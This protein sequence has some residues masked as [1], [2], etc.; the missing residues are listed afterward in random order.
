M[1]WGVMSPIVVAERTQTSEREVNNRCGIAEAAYG[2]AGK[3]KFVPV[4]RD[5]SIALNDGCIPDEC[6]RDMCAIQ[7]LSH[8]GKVVDQ[9]RW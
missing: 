7:P 8:N 6:G 1:D 5:H 9:L 3:A 4:G 2:P